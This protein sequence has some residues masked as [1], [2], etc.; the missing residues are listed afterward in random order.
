M[1][2]I[3]SENGCNKTSGMCKGCAGGS[4]RFAEAYAQIHPKAT[5]EQRLDMQQLMLAVLKKAR[6]DFIEQAI[7]DKVVEPRV[8]E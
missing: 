4:N 1:P 5:A 7:E 2:A 8:A 3:C 6:A